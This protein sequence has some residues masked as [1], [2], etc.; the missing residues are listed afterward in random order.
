MLY[1]VQ[2]AADVV[3]QGVE[4]GIRM[5]LLVL[6]GA[7]LVERPVDAVARLG[8]L[9]QQLKAGGIGGFAEVVKVHQQIGALGVVL[10]EQ[11]R[12]LGLPIADRVVQIQ[13]FDGGQQFAL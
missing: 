8:Q 10:A 11:L 5:E 3:A 1:I 2:R 12:G 6:V 4:H 9:V 13:G 7:E